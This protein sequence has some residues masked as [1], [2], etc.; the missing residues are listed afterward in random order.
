MLKRKNKRYITLVE[1][2]IV[3]FLI[4][5]VTGALAYNFSGSIDEGK[6]FTTKSNIEKIHTILDL[7]L[8][9]NPDDRENIGS[10]WQSFVGKSQ[11][12]KNPD[13]LIRDG[14]GKEFKVE[15]HDGEIVITSDKYNQYKGSKGTMFGDS[16]KQTR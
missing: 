8:A 5:M 10:G 12:V 9:S 6:A 14:W 11:L 1:I 13:S 3:M 15:E 4:A 16:N 2:M 7:H